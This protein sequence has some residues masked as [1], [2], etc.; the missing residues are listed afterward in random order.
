MDPRT[1]KSKSEYEGKH[2]FTK[3]GKEEFII[4][5]LN[6]VA[7]VT[8]KFI[9]SGLERKTSISNIKAGISNP[10]AKSCICFD[11]IEQEL[12]GCIFKTNQGYHIKIIAAESKAKVTYQFIDQFGY[13]GCTTIQN[14]R[15]G[16]IR[17]PYHM[18][19][20]GGYFGVTPFSGDK[21]K[22]LY[23]VWHSM[24]VRG[25]GARQ[26][27]ISE[28]YYNS[29]QYYDNSAVCNEWRC[30]AFFADWYMGSIARL[31]PNFAYEL[32]KDLLYKYY[33][34]YTNG[35]KLYS[36]VTCVLIPHDLN[37][38]LTNYDRD[39]YD[40]NKIRISI[41]EM[42]EY[43]YKNNAMSNNTYEAIKVQ[44]YNNGTKR[45]YYYTSEQKRYFSNYFSFNNLPDVQMPIRKPITDTMK[46]KSN[47]ISGGV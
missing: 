1:L 3:D 32:D 9:G 22:D 34:S 14:I 29:T 5:N 47:N 21:Y 44:Y 6:S 33:K 45:T 17:N 30:Y 40:H 35:I 26:K 39:G 10:F 23:N 46:K 11:T 38:Q 42:T 31:N 18:N 28:G 19:E 41:I 36:P 12:V 25:T 7:D 27:Y 2:F 13:V 8:I 24:L 43:Y 37:I 16:Q 4:T 20:F 15:N